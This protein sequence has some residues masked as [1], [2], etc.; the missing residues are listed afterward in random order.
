M[1][2]K[3]T[4]DLTYMNHTI[5]RN[6]N[7]MTIYEEYMEMGIIWFIRMCIVMRIKLFGISIFNIY[8]FMYVE[9][10]ILTQ[11]LCPLFNHESSTLST[12]STIPISVFFIPNAI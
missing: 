5:P 4:W 12:I 3:N 10:C 8:Y 9:Y 2:Y 7:M 6:Y 1:N 11:N